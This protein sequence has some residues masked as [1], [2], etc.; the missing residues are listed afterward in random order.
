MLRAKLRVAARQWLL[1]NA[2]PKLH[3]NAKEPD[4]ASA[5]LVV[6]IVRYADDRH[7]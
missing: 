1:A 2:L 5:P 4:G 6:N 3:G 7:P